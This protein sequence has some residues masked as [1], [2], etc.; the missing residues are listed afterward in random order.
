MHPTV[1]PVCDFNAKA[2]AEALHGAMKGLG[3]N[4]K[5]LIKVLCHRSCEQRVQIAHAFKEIYDKDL[6]SQLKNELSG[7]F[8][9]L[10]VALTLPT[11]EFLAREVHAALHRPGT[12]EGDLIEIFCSLNNSEM[13]HL[14]LAYLK[15]YGKPL[16]QD[17]KKDTSGLIEHLLVSFIQHS[18]KEGDDVDIDQ[19][20]TDVKT[21]YR[22]G[23]ANLGTDEGAFAYILAT[24]SWAHIRKVKAEYKVASGNSLKKAVSSEFSGPTEKALLAVLQCAKSR[25]S[26]YAKVLNDAVKGIGTK[27]RDLIRVIVSRCDIDLGDIKQEYQKMFGKSLNEDVHGDTSG[28]YAKALL[29][30]IN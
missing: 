12:N 25:T 16:V 8:E 18:R 3:T 15:M 30:L 2:D 22:A 29:E 19:V 26:Y 5:A 9:R 23:E 11:S 6:E 4:E 21:L 10:M 27:D 13:D 1:H 7:D 28:D 17:V 20:Y 24:R 14:R